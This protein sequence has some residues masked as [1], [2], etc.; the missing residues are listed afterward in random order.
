MEPRGYCH[1]PSLMDTDLSI[2]K[3]F[4]LTERVRMQFRID[5]FNAV[6][7]SRTSARQ[8]GSVNGGNCRTA[9]GVGCDA[10]C[11]TTNNVISSQTITNNFGQATTV[12]GNAGREIQYG[13]H[14][15]F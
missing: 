5:L 7:P 4:K 3:N 11:S 2:D 10:P 12:V 6:Q 14:I 9:A 13:L 8:I 1:G 15:T